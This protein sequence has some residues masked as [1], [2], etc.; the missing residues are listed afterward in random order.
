MTLFKPSKP[1]ILFAFSTVSSVLVWEYCVVFSPLDSPHTV[2]N[3]ILRRHPHQKYPTNALPSTDVVSSVSF[4]TSLQKPSTSFALNGDRPKL[5][6]KK[7][8]HFDIF[9]WHS[10]TENETE[11]LKTNP[12]PHYQVDK[13]KKCIFN[14]L[15][16]HSTWKWT[17]SSV[18]LKRVLTYKINIAKSAFNHNKSK[19]FSSLWPL[20]VFMTCFSNLLSSSLPSQSVQVFPGSRVSLPPRHTA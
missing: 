16:N 10:V 15:I 6:S 5:K 7:N 14:V 11:A 1:I 2:A 8:T 4:A 19:V 3:M 17:N 20:F 18:P 9:R 12:V 13:I